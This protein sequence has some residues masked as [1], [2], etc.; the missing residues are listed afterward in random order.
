MGLEAVYVDQQQDG[1]APDEER[2]PRA[3]RWTKGSVATLPD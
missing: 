2:L 1:Q 3:G